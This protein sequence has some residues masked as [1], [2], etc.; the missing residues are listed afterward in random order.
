MSDPSA[1]WSSG[2]PPVRILYGGTFD[3]VHVAHLRNVL[4]A[5]AAVADCLGVSTGRVPVHL[6]PCAQPAHR[7]QPGAGAQDRLRMLES[8]IE[9]VPGFVADPREL[10]R[11][12][13][14][15][16]VDTLASF[17]HEFG[18]DVALILL[19]GRDA[20]RNFHTWHRWLE[21]VRLAHIM[22]M[23]RP[24]ED[25][26]FDGPVKDLL[27]THETDTLFDLINA[28]FGRIH[29]RTFR[30][31]DISSTEIR[32]AVANGKSIRYL[33]PDGVYTHIQTHRLYQQ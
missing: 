28:P 5:Q 2:V 3:P 4:E 17:R 11:S 27:S 24:G 6:L 9:G 8:A 32:A 25:R 33:V 1:S 14:S 26:P 31:L 29:E 15:Y 10:Y 12:G 7:A 23:N 21:I 16:T 19:M 30:L 13:P 20:F 22:V 18:P